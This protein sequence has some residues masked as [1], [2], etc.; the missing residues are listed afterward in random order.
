MPIVVVAAMV[1]SL[2]SCGL[3]DDEALPPSERL[4]D[5]GRG[6]DQG[7]AGHDLAASTRLPDGSVLF[8]FGDTYLGSVEGDTR[9]TTGLLNQT[10]ALIPEGE[11]IC[12]DELRY[13]TGPGGEVRDLLADPPTQGSAYWPVD[14]AVRDEQV[15]MLFRWVQRASDEALDIEVLGTGLAVADPDELEFRAAAT[16]LVEGGDPLPSALVAHDG[17]LVTLVC[18]GDLDEGDCRLHLLDTDTVSIGRLLPPPAV[19]LAAA[20][21]G[22]GRTTVDGEEVWRASS[23]P[24]LCGRL[25]VAV[26]DGD[27]WDTRPVLEPEPTG[28]GLCYAGRVQET[29]S[30]PDVLVATWVESPQ[31][32]SDADVYWPH[33]ERIDLREE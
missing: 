11:D 13:L 5:L 21:M 17:D 20:E 27:G 33:V 15:W 16:L 25:D 9:T 24:E 29:Y 8:A 6:N 30:S 18:G 26:Q 22:L 19:G 3:F 32:R 23:M 14:L 31:E 4:C 7:V 1:V 28:G 10:G 12:S 2:A